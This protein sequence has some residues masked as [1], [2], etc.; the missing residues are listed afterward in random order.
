MIYYAPLSDQVLTDL[1]PGEVE[2]LYP[3]FWLIPLWEE[4]TVTE[5]TSFDGNFQFVYDSVSLTALQKCARYYKWTVM[6]GWQL[7]PMPSTLAFGIYF[8]KCLE[9]WHKLLA[10]SIDKDTA[11]LRCTRLAGLFG[12]H[13]IPNRTERTKETLVR[14]VVWYLDQ[15][16]DDQ[17]TTTFRPDGTPAVEYSFMLHIG[18]IN[19]HTCYLA[20]HIDRIVEFMGELYPADYKTSKMALNE[21]F[22]AKFKPNTQVSN[23]LLATLILAGTVSAVPKAPKGLMI[24]GIQLGVN[25]TRFNRSI[26]TF[27]ELE[28]NEQIKDLTAWIQ[29]AALYAEN[30][31]W[32][33]NPDSCDK[34]GGCVFRSICA[35][36]PAKWG[37]SLRSN[38]V[39][40]TWDPRKSR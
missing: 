31:H 17:A 26:I 16:R 20:G 40:K 35:S 22:F 18:E 24:D 6:E 25:F 2:K 38:F 39:R 3:N 4:P 13:L 1:Y 33:A 9:V 19:D 32:P 27:S 15:F 14:A 36:T 12:E 37:R 10:T 8:H 28:I 21:Q 7:D 29:Q 30:G 5:N 23:Y 11:L 34:Y